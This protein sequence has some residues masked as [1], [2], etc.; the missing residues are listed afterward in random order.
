MCLRLQTSCR[1]SV[2]QAEACQ[3][4]QLPVQSPRR[5]DSFERVSSLPAGFL[6]DGIPSLA[7]ERARRT[8]AMHDDRETQDYPS[9]G[10]AWYVVAVLTLAY[11]FS[12]IDRQILSLLVG[13]I[14]RA[15]GIS[16]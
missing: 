15:L 13:P 2:R 6:L 8:R 12:F 4:S 5:N 9:V 1:G 14:Q 11:V 3:P 7:G 16:V 10:Y